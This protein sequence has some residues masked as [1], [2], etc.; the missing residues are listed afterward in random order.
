MGKRPTEIKLTWHAQK[1]LRERNNSNITYDTRNIIKTPCKWFAPQD[2]IPNSA[3]YLHSLYTCRKS[4]ALG[5]ITNGDIEVIYNKGTKTAITIL[6]VK[7]KFKP[8]TQY[9]KPRN[10]RRN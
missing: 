1:R 5:W 8:I 6:E 4:K 3:L 2:L 10:T 9:I 7:D